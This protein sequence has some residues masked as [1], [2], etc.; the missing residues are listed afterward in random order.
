MTKKM[1]VIEGY[2]RDER[3]ALAILDRIS[4]FPYMPRSISLT[5]F[6]YKKGESV[7]LSG[8]ALSIKDLNLFIKELEETGF[9]KSVDI[10]QRPWVPL[11][12]N[13]PKVLNYTLVCNF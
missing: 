8:H 9:F 10:K 1:R 13:R 6:K 12:N 7:E 11:P 3:N 4:T 5:D 2:V